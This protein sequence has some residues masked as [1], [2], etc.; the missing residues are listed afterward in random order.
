MD[1][2]LSSGRRVVS[3]H[4]VLLYETEKCLVTGI[5]VEGFKR[6]YKIVWM[7]WLHSSRAGDEKI[8]MFLSPFLDS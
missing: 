8:R 4:V 3:Y 7:S 6:D 1:G 5:Q 2:N